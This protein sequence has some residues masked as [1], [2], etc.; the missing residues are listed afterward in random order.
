MFLENLKTRAPSKQQAVLLVVV[1]V[2]VVAAAAVAVSVAAV[3]V[4][5]SFVVPFVVLLFLFHWIL[6]GVSSSHEKSSGMPCHVA[7]AELC[8]ATLDVAN[9]PCIGVNPST[10]TFGTDGCPSVYIYVYI[11][12]Y[13]FLFVRP[14]QT[15]NPTESADIFAGTSA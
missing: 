8:Q 9:T 1:V 13:F 6:L 10:V 4:A 15:L 12:I 11:Y 3:A 14:L 2:V 7:E 5:A